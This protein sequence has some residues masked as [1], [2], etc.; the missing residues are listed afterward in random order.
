MICLSG[1]MKH[2]SS[3]TGHI[4]SENDIILD[5]PILYLRT[6]ITNEMNNE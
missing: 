3:I 6:Y 5:Y 4:K 2:H 1:S